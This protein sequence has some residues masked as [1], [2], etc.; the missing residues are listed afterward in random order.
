MMCFVYAENYN[1]ENNNCSME[2]LLCVKQGAND[3]KA[4]CG[5]IIISN[6]QCQKLKF[7]KIK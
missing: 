5:S 4:Y 2:R 6:L 7:R 3:L 1:N